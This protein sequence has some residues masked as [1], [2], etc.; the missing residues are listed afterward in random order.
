MR[1]VL[2]EKRR[3]LAMLHEL[4]G[5]GNIAV[6]T[7]HTRKPIEPADWIMA[8]RHVAQRLLALANDQL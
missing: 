7:L 1:A 6:V 2:A 4:I 8:L 5:Q 3:D